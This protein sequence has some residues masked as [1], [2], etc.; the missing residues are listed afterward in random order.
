MNK[1]QFL[2]NLRRMLRRLPADELERI[3][4]YYREMIDDKVESGQTEEEAVG[5]LG[6]IRALAQKV[7][8]ENPNR[9]PVSIGKIIGISVLS[10]FG[11]VLV[12]SIALT[13]VGFTGSG[14]HIV[15]GISFQNKPSNYTYKTYQV[16][17]DGIKL[18][19]LSA[20]DKSILIEPSDSD[21]IQVK[22]IS[23]Q[24]EKYNFSCKDATLTITNE[25]QMKWNH[26]DFDDNSTPRITISLPK[27]YA[28]DIKANTSN[29]Y[30]Q[31][32]ELQNIKNLSCETS[33]SYIKVSSFKAQTVKLSTKNAAISLNSV[34][35]TTKLTADT[36][37]AV[38][39]LSDI[40]S[41]D[42]ALQTQNALITGTIHGNEDDYTINSQ[43][44]NA[45]NNLKNRTGGSK[46]LSVETTNAIISVSFKN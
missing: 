35:A 19:D 24:Y 28:G 29:S 25:E 1:E 20:E 9:R 13:C 32:K 8:L 46:N 44:T 31:V 11:I 36:Q 41:P 3:L 34:A 33:N 21:Q 12:A 4:S 38:I 45:I 18:L 5:G 2:R 6:D 15:N 23:N 10:L 14:I 30:I 42:I 7:L 26:W 27:N 40:E 37:N 22:Y 17:S 39:N 16:K 43:T